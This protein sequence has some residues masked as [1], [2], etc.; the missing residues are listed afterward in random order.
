MRTQPRPRLPFP[1]L[2]FGFHMQRAASALLSLLSLLFLT[3]QTLAQTAG[4]TGGSSTSSSATSSS[5]A[6]SSGTQSQP[7]TQGTTTTPP[8]T[9]SGQTLTGTSNASVP[10]AQ[11]GAPL[12]T[13][14]ANNGSVLTNTVGRPN[15]HHGNHT[16]MGTSNTYQ[17]GAHG[18][19]NSNAV[20]NG[21]NS[22]TPMFV[23]AQ[24][25]PS[26]RAPASSQVNGPPNRPG[27]V[28]QPTPAAPTNP[29]Q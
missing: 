21:T 7:T 4:S 20:V 15:T 23:P 19:V 22:F 18:T 28:A 8:A 12:Q 26:S 16:T 2:S 5:T 1:S 6:P 13:N 29:P 11:I 14:P 3:T 10:P 9:T 17:N 27:T 25:T 24:T